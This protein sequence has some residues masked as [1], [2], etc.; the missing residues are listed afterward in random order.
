M[1]DL[2][3]GTVTFLLTDIE[4]STRLWEQHSEAMR[5]AL[6]RHDTLVEQIVAA[7]EGKVVRPRGEGDSRFAVFARATDAVAAAVGLQEEFYSEPWPTPTPL[8]VRMALHTGEADLREGDYYGSVVNRCARLRAVAHGG[9]IVVSLA[10][11]ELVRDTLPAGTTLRDLGAHR[12]RDLQHPERVFQLIVDGLPADFPTLTT[13]DARPNN[14]PPQRDSLIGREEEVAEVSALLRRPEVGLVTLTGPG[15]TGKTRLALQVATELLPV[16]PDGIF[17]VDLVPIHDPDLVLTAISRALGLQESAP[18]A[19]PASLRAY[20]HAKQMLLVLDNFE[21]VVAAATRVTELLAPTAGLKVLVT[22]RERLHLRGEQ[23]YPV[24]PL[25][26]PDLQ[27]RSPL[28]VMSQYAAV[29]LFIQR[30]QAAKPDFEVTNANARAVAELCVRLDGLPLAI[31]LA[32]A[33]VKVLS[34]AALLQRLSH[35]LQVL[36]GGPRDAPARQQTLRA[37]LEWSYQLLERDEQ[38]LFRRLAVFVGG[39]TLAAAEAVTGEPAPGVSPADA[40]PWL[41]V[42]DL[43]QS[44]VDKSL[45]RGVGVGAAPATSPSAPP[46]AEPRFTLLETIR[47]YAAER[48]QASEEVD[49]LRRRHALYYLQLA[50][51]AEPELLGTHQALWLERLEAEHDNLRSVLQWAIATNDGEIGLRLAG[52]LWR[53]WFVHG[54]LSQG[55]IWLELALDG[56]ESQPAAWRAKALDGA[57]VMAAHR[58]DYLRA[59]QFF[60]ESLRVWQTVDNKQGIAVSLGNLGRSAIEQGDYERAHR[61]LEDSR[62]IFRELNDSRGISQLLNDLGLL[63]L[64]QEDFARARSLYDESLARFRALGHKGG[65][66]ALLGNLG[67]V[68]LRQ[69]DYPAAGASYAESLAMFRELDDRRGVATCFEDLAANIGVRVRPEDIARILGNA[70]ALREAIDAPLTPA[71]RA[72]YERSVA[73]IR[74][75]LDEP[76][77]R[78]AWD[79]GRAMSLDQSIALAVEIVAGR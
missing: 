53:F 4:G 38:V 18:A 2:L 1:P 26:L 23:E 35:R 8:R 70:E 69:G 34:P 79:E 40:E 57:G 72:A 74:E 44:L 60:G 15:G 45:V 14:L 51:L 29:A 11:A 24:S 61:L 68:A 20:L 78:A 37:T 10:T 22:S 71:D 27:R 39:W 25:T 76:T 12:L 54:H 67:L 21:Q 66:A 5:T 65:V 48:L 32:A 13:L 7:N 6:V 41:P 19:L 3:T 49:A 46:T 63:A 30:A 9:Q 59:S 31:E 28:E 47:E 52:A 62:A 43:L 73:T 64:Y 36:T 42:L 56:S 17:F 75:R 77:L 16:F 55:G 58:G 50:E 33:R